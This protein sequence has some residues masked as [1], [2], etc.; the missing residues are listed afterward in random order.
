MEKPSKKP[1]TLEN[2]FSAVDNKYRTRKQLTEFV[3]AYRLQ[4]IILPRVFIQQINRKY[5][6]HSISSLKVFE[7]I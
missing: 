4:Y 6:L 2:F 3:S 1:S 7:K 5:N